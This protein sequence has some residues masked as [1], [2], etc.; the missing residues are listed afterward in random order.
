MMYINISTHLSNPTECIIPG[1]GHGN[2]LQYSFLE[3]PTDRR[4]WRATVHG[5]VKSQP[6]LKQLSTHR[7][8]NNE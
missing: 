8:Y 3:N 6:Q 4:A 1:G 5:V 7:V 2:L